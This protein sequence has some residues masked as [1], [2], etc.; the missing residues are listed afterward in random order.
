MAQLFKLHEGKIVPASKE[1]AE[2]EV[3]AAPDEE[4][5]KHLLT[6]LD[7]DLHSL[8]STL[9]P[10]ELSRIEIES[11]HAFIIWKRPNHFTYTNKLQFEVSSIGF[12]LHENRLVIMQSE[13]NTPFDGKEFRR[14]KSLRHVMLMFLLQTI[15]HFVDHLRVMRMVS[16]EIQSK[17]QQSVGNEH[18]LHMFSLSESLIYYLNAI[19]SNQTVLQKLQNLARKLQLDEDERE[20]LEDIVI[21]NTQC[22][23]QAE[24][25]SQVLSGLMD[26]RGNIINNNMNELLKNLAIINIIFL[27]LNL[28]ASIGG[29][30]EYSAMTA[31]LPIWLSY[32]AFCVGLT[33]AGWLMWRVLVRQTPHALKAQRSEGIIDRLKRLRR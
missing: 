3:Y 28:V 16:N 31:G 10:E 27:P 12:F 18:L 7:T 24:I 25:Y 19:T 26:A 29:M 4:E 32:G 33:L 22:L 14:L 30:S 11:D 8:N 20:I 2:I 6:V 9:D 13:D 15:H 23:R 21:E 17:L 1:D 5:K